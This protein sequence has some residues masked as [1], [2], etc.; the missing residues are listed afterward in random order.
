MATTSLP[1]QEFAE[2]LHKAFSAAENGPVFVTDQGTPAYVLLSDA[3][4]QRLLVQKRSIA[5]LLA[6]PNAADVE[7]EAPC[8]NL[9]VRPA[10]F[11]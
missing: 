9:A 8:A 4:Y 10:D 7:F 1:M 11:T 6:M 2:D 3:D 5:D